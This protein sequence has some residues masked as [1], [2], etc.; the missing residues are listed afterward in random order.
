M[1][2]ALRVT[3][4]SLHRDIFLNALAKTDKAWPDDISEEIAKAIPKKRRTVDNGNEY[5]P[6]L[7]IIDVNRMIHLD[8]EDFQGYVRV[9][10]LLPFLTF[11]MFPEDFQKEAV[12]RNFKTGFLLPPAD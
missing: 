9:F 4:R 3:Q 6:E 1:A 8:V 2:K 12:R 11:D 7:V 10:V 5:L